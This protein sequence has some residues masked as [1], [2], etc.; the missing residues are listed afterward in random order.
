MIY[1]TCLVF[2]SV[3]GFEDSWSGILWDTHNGNSYDFFHGKSE[4]M[5][6]QG[7]V[8][9]SSPCVGGAYRQPDPS[10]L[11]LALSTWLGGASGSSTMDAPPEIRPVLTGGK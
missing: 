9:F 4:L 3:D 11:T 10:P 2:D 8:L 1:L 7:K 6:Y 5:Y